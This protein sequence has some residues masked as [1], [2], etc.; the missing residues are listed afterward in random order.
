MF[1]TQTS[2]CEG[3]SGDLAK[4]WLFSQA[5]MSLYFS[6]CNYAKGCKVLNDKNL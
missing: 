2:F 5:T 1:V 3:S 6:V 4:R